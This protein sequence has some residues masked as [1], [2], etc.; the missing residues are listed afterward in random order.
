MLR[1]NGRRCGGSPCAPFGKTL[2]RTGASL[3]LTGRSAP[4]GG[5]RTH[6]RGMDF[7]KHPMKRP[8]RPV[9]FRFRPMD[10]FIQ[11]RFPSQKRARFVP[12]G[13][14]KA[15][16]SG[17]CA[18]SLGADASLS[19]GS[20]FRSFPCARTSARK[21]RIL[22][23]KKTPARR[24]AETVRQNDARMTGPDGSPRRQARSYASP[25]ADRRLTCCPPV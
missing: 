6:I 1:R 15:P 2:K 16:G 22:S 11:G 14:K 12:Y 19:D 8:F 23:V 5:P 17:S 24:I 13:G 3:R 9:D 21:Y 25:H 20:V 18:G 4:R 7:P 10:F